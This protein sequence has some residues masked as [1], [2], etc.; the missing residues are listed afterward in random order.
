MVGFPSEAFFLA[1]QRRMREQQ[2][3]FRSLGFFDVTFGVHVLPDTGDG[4]EHRFVL[5]FEVFDCIRAQAVRDFDTPVDFV[6]SG[7]LAAWRAMLENVKGRGGADV[8]HSINTLTH[9]GE[10][11]Q[12]RYDDP[13]GHDKLYRFAES[14]QAFFDLAA[15]LDV[16]FAPAGRSPAPAPG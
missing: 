4:P 10:G 15:T 16:D 7:R 1:L 11:L 14:V 6:L 5:G 2:E 3:R 8:A 12:V 13:E 9:F